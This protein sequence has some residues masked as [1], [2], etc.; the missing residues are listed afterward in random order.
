MDEPIFISDRLPDDK[1]MRELFAVEGLELH[2]EDSRERRWKVKCRA[3]SEDASDLTISFSARYLPYLA[4][5]N[6]YIGKQ[7]HDIENPLLTDEIFDL[8]DVV[9]G[10]DK[11]CGPGE[12]NRVYRCGSGGYKFYS[13]ARAGKNRNLHFPAY[14][15][16]QAERDG[17]SL[18]LLISSVE[19]MRYFLG[20]DLELSRYIFSFL[21]DGSN[22]QLFRIGRRDLVS[23]KITELIFTNH[24]LSFESQKIIAWLYSSEYG[25]TEMLRPSR[26]VRRAKV[27]AEILKS[28][29]KTVYPEFYLP[30]QP[31]ASLEVLGKT[32]TIELVTSKG[33]V[34]MNVFTVTKILDTTYKPSTPNIKVCLEQRRTKN[35]DKS[36][37]YFG[38]AR[39]NEHD[40]PKDA[41]NRS[42]SNAWVPERASPKENKDFL[43]LRKMP[44]KVPILETLTDEKQRNVVD[45]HD[46]PLI[47]NTSTLPGADAGGK[48]GLVIPKNDDKNRE[49]RERRSLVLGDS[50][51]TNLRFAIPSTVLRIDR[52]IEWAKIEE[53]PFEFHMLR[54]MVERFSKPGWKSR[55]FPAQESR[56]LYPLMNL[57]ELGRPNP[58]KKVRVCRS[59]LV[60]RFDGQ[61]FCVT[62]LDISRNPNIKRESI[63]LYAIL[64]RGRTDVPVRLL[65][66]LFEQRLSPAIS[67][68]SWPNSDNHGGGYVATVI[69][70]RKHWI[71]NSSAAADQMDSTI[72]RLLEYKQFCQ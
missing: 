68:G 65:S 7:L 70:H 6:R 61:G 23:N 16:I 52:D 8:R 66:Y 41:G 54:G 45:P 63:G 25:L 44:L 11:L 43:G 26:T 59:G 5:A 35:P 2:P 20:R 17:D 55:F 39:V 53:L 30:Y 60:A 29:A 67:L 12:E 28:D 9:S 58:S 31:S 38:R 40:L 47:D 18:P 33:S 27:R 72:D 1:V 50:S 15:I 22:D 51:L 49:A 13:I 71:R 32:Q 19:L 46:T 64:S 37:P 10:S 21:G 62:L 56:H 3:L 69:Q 36:P 57:D 42:N 14:Q 34:E 48:T 4:L 24:E